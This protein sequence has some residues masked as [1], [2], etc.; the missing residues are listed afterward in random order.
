M[1]KRLLALGLVVIAVAF[2][3][4][5]QAAPAQPVPDAALAATLGL[6]APADCAQ[7]DASAAAVPL[8]AP[9]TAAVVCCTAADRAACNQECAPLT[10][11]TVCIH[12]CECYCY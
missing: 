10:G 7:A 8:A 1:K 12:G 5:A 2:A 4:V 11:H 6:A 9:A 3:G